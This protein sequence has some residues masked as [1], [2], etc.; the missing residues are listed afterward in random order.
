M[1]NPANL[2][3]HGIRIVELTSQLAGSLTAQLLGDQGADV[4]AIHPPGYDSEDLQHSVLMRNK[5]YLELDLESQAGQ[6]EAFTLI[7]RADVLISNWRPG[8]MDKLGF[9]KA[10]LQ[11]LNPSL[12]CLSLP[13]FSETDEEHKQLAATEGLLAAY[14]GLFREISPVRDKLGL[15]PV[16][17][18]LP[19]PSVYAAVHGATAVGAA[20]IARHQDGGGEFIEVPL[21][22]AAMSA[23]SGLLMKIEDQPLRYDVPPLPKNIQQK[24]IPAAAKVIKHLPG[25]FQEKVFS[26][27]QSVMPPLFQN[28]PCRDG[29]LIFIC[30]LEHKIQTVNALKN[31]WHLR[32][33]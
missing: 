20:L 14:S 4:V 23:L 18:P 12:I 5:S 2:P 6:Q 27:A 11:Q 13:G 33:L 30:A 24:V 22:D 3:F 1:S 7:E 19:L 25:S 31:L 29:R 21:F 8:V 15:P 32:T 9:N 10:Q 17:T 16:Y 26:A 28:Y